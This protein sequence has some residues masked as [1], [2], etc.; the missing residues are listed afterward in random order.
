MGFWVLQQTGKKAQ[1]LRAVGTLTLFLT[2]GTWFE[3]QVTVGLC[4]TFETGRAGLT[5]QGPAFPPVI[6]ST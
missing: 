1:A 3:W 2:W 4:I 5:F 6:D